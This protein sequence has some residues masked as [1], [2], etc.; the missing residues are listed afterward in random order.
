VDWELIRAEAARRFGVKRFR[1][2]Q[3]E[4]IE[5]VLAG[6]DAL[7]V[8]PTGAGKSLCFQLPALFLDGLTVV[9]SPLIALLH[10]QLEHLDEADVEAARLDS[11][12]TRG[13]Q[14]TLERD[15]RKGSRDIVLLTPE[16]LQSP[17]HLEPLAKRK[18]ALFVV[19]E[20]HCVSQWGHDFRPA[21]LGLRQVIK[22]LRHP[23]ILAL[24][25]TAPPDLLRDIIDGLG[26][27]DPRVVRTGIER[28]NLRFEVHP[29]VNREEKERCLLDIL[30][31]CRGG[32]GIV[33]ATT[34]RQVQEVHDLLLSSGL[35][36]VRYHGQM[37]LSER[38]A[39]QESFMSGRTRLIVATNAF[40]L[41]VDKP[42]VRAVVHWSFPA[43]LESYYQEAG[44]AGRDGKDARCALLYRLEDKRTWDFLLG[45]R[46]PHSEEISRFIEV[47]GRNS[48]Q[49]TGIDAK[50]LAEA[51]RLSLRRTNVLSNTLESMGLLRADGSRLKLEPTLQASEIAKIA[52]SFELRREAD[53]NRLRTMMRYAQST[54]CRMQYL[55]EYFGEATGER[56]GRCDNCH[57]PAREFWKPKPAKA[58]PKAQL[59]PGRNVRHKR[60][61]TGEVVEIHG[62]QVT[63]AFVRGGQRQILAP[64]LRIVD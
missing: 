32:T 30:H 37:R 61:G 4:L 29:C 15:I 38:E 53:R 50:E 16:R 60:F 1:A 62:D 14:R 41:G 3:R 31:N 34:I 49:H 43:S 6:Q 35:D 45:G 10:D 9:V 8:L 63:V 20:A 22:T 55:R 33:Y 48:S 42:D 18:V 24:T 21:Y 47:L 39:V 40:G 26:M 23:T 57:K 27:T 44:R 54:Y 46:Y 52:R 25:A 7:G 64:Y 5:C 36:A 51:T 28:E 11:T 59:S 13:R 2:G 17:Q 58:Q 19:D 12:L 56:C